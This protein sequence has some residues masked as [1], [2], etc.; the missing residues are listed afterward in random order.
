MNRR[1]YIAGCA[2]VCISLS[3]CVSNTGDDGVTSGETIRL[4]YGRDPVDDHADVCE[5]EDLPSDA[6][7]EFESAMESEDRRHRID[8]GSALV[9]SDCYETGTAIEFEGEHYDVSV[10]AYGG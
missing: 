3:G 10:D 5:F 8:G 4:S 1:S 7:R 2:A 9:S 6:Q